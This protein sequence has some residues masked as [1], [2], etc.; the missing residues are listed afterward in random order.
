MGRDRKPS[1]I[2]IP[3]EPLRQQPTVSTQDE[4]EVVIQLPTGESATVSLHGATVTSWKSVDGQERLFLSE[5]AVMDGSKPIRGGIPIC[6]PVRACFAG[7]GLECGGRV[8]G[9]GRGS[10]VWTN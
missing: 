9:V 8:R 7:R 1:A 4:N 10:F 6:F 5:K 2:G 3:T